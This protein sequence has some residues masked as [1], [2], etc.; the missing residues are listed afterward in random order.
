MMYKKDFKQL[1]NMCAEID[2]V[3]DRQKMVVKMCLFCVENNPRFEAH[4]FAEWIR[5]VREGESLVGLR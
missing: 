3:E 1:A 4:R 5:R 2:N